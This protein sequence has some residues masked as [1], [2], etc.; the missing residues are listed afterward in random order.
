ID[1]TPSTEIGLPYNKHMSDVAEWCY[2]PT[3][4]ILESFTHVLQNDHLPVYKKGYFG[5]YDAKAN[6]ERMPV[7]Q[8][9]N[10]DKIILLQLLPE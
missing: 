8:K 7:G 9:F 5:T 1:L 10:E 6:R 2:L 3:W 4:I